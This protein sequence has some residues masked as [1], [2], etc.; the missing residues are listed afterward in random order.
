MAFRVV[1]RAPWCSGLGR[2]LGLEALGGPI[3]PLAK[4]DPDLEPEARR[5]GA[6]AAGSGKQQIH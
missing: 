3:L 5:P 2:L 6:L 1:F 4:G